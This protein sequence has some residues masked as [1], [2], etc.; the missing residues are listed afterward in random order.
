M[1]KNLND[2]FNEATPQELDQ[3]SD[4]LNAPKLPDEVLG[5]I[6]NKVYVKTNLTKE[7]KNKRSLWLRFGVIAACLVM[8]LG[9]FIFALILMSTMILIMV[10]VNILL[11]YSFYKVF[12]NSF[13][14]I[15]KITFVEIS[16]HEIELTCIIPFV[17]SKIPLP[18]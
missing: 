17:N 1:K 13:N 10:L 7:K 3:F 18:S 5:S 14:I 9:V 2:F 6:K 12:V 4:E 15:D 16:L 11:S 8:I